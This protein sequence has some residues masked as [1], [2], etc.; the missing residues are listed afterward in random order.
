M[1][2][3]VSDVFG[4]VM[5]RPVKPDPELLAELEQKT[6]NVFY[7]PDA[8]GNTYVPDQDD[9]VIPFGIRSLL[10]FTRC[11]RAATSSP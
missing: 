10:G 1:F 4:I 8:A 5:N 11:C 3:Q 9:F 6:Y 7:V 2:A